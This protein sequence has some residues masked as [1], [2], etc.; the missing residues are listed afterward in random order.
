M[1]FELTWSSLRILE[2]D[3]MSSNLPANLN[4]SHIIFRQLTKPAHAEYC[5]IW[6]HFLLVSQYFHH[7]GSSDKKKSSKKHSPIALLL[8]KLGHSQPSLVDRLG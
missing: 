6:S 5:I 3:D 8:S 2:T 7:H 1:R 4:D